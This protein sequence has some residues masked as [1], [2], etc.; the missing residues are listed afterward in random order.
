MPIIPGGSVSQDRSDGGGA[1]ADDFSDGYDET[2]TVRHHEKK[3]S[4]KLISRKPAAYKRADD[5]T[6]NAK[7]LLQETIVVSTAPHVDD[8]NLAI[9]ASTAESKQ[10]AEIVV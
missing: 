6:E 5:T 3:T 9:T 2:A 4:K 10:T 7:E 1:G 8:A